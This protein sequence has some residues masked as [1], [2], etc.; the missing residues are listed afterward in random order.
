MD[1]EKG[2]TTE[3]QIDIIGLVNYFQEKK[4][5]DLPKCLTLRRGVG[6][7]R[8][9][10]SVVLH[11]FMIIFEKLDMATIADN[12]NLELSKLET[13]IAKL[14]DRLSPTSERAE[15]KEKVNIKK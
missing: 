6:H 10:A 4:I 3:K 2:K 7:N 12:V 15:M 1:E 14:E 13:K 11:L 5:L 9:F 8:A